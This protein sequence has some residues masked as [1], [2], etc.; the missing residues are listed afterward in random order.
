MERSVMT[1]SLACH[2]QLTSRLDK[3][4]P[5]EHQCVVEEL[6]GLQGKMREADEA[7][8]AMRAELEAAKQQVASLESQLEESRSKNSNDL[9]RYR[10]TLRVR[11]R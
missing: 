5:V 10:N 6:A 8:A 11:L 2:L 7:A 4:D 1:D 9:Q 3:V